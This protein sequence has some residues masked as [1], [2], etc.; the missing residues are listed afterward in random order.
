[1]VAKPELSEAKMSSREV[2]MAGR[3]E[4]FGIC[5]LQCSFVWEKMGFPG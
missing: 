5:M 4:M 3:R 2:V 1:M